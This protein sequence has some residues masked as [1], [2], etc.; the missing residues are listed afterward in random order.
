ME[1]ERGR[2]VEG[3]KLEDPARAAGGVLWRLRELIRSS[4]FTGHRLHSGGEQR[5]LLEA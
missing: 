1:E 2:E 3:Y 5:F 4:S